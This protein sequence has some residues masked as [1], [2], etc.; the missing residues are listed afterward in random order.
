MSITEGFTPEYK[1]YSQIEF[2]AVLKWQALA[3]MRTEWPYIFEE[4]DKFLTETYQSKFHPVHFVSTKGD[5]LISY[6]A[7]VRTTLKHVGQI[8]QVCGFGNMFT[9][10]PHRGEGHGHKLLR[11]ATE[12]IRQSEVDLGILYCDNKLEPFY[13]SEGW[14][15][16]GSPTRFGNPSEYE[17]SD[18]Q[19]MMIFVSDKGKQ[20][21]ADFENLPVYVD[22]TW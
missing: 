17:D 13:A 18:E 7:I 22:W 20:N 12:M 19:R 9:F 3:F 6:A 16:P 11:M 4:D 1:I 2:P 21:R 14:I 15:T 10:P 5:L 8:Y